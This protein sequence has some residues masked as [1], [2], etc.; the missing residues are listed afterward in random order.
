[1]EEKIDKLISLIEQQNKAWS[2]H[3]EMLQGIIKVIDSKVNAKENLLKEHPTVREPTEVE[4]KQP[5]NSYG[6]SKPYG[7]DI[8]EQK[9][10][11]QRSFDGAPPKQQQAPIAKPQPEPRPEPSLEPSGERVVSLKNP[12]KENAPPPMPAPQSKAEMLERQT[13]L[14]NS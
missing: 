8:E 3:L 2:I 11:P 1:M 10:A 14:P 5:L 6:D 7:V 12:Q 9:K 13:S 4:F